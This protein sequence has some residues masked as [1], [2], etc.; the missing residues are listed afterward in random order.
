MDKNLNRKVNATEQTGSNVSLNRRR[1]IGGVTATAVGLSI[2]P[3]HVL[4]GSKY[5]APSDKINVA[6]IGTGTQG[7]KE[8]PAL[9]EV[10][11]AQVIAVC[12][13]QK[14]AIGYYDWG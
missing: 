1:F 13:P 9:L 4:G 10:K 7:L 3:A 8:L 2:I 12:D 6:Y 14:Y 5:V 11:E